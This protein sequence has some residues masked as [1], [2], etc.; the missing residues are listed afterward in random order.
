MIRFPF[1]VV[2]IQYITTIMLL[3]AFAGRTVI[4]KSLCL[5]L[6]VL[7][8]VPT[9]RAEPFSLRDGDRVVLIGSTLIEREQRYGYWETRLTSRWPE[10]NIIFRNLG[11]SG[12]T[13]WGESRAG[14]DTPAQGYKR[15]LDH[16]LA[17][18]PTV[19]IIGYGTNESFAG[20]AGLPRFQKQLEKL[21][22]DLAPSKARIVLLAP[23]LAEASRW[24]AGKVD[25]RNHDLRLYTDAI[26]QIAER[27]RATFVPEFCQRYGVADPLTDDGMQLTAF[28]YWSTSYHL[29]NELRVAWS[30]ETV[31]LDGQ[32]P[33]R[34]QQ[35]F[36]PGP[37]APPGTRK[38]YSQ[39]DCTV[40]ARNLKPGKYTLKIDGKAVRTADAET[41]MK[42][43]DFGIL[44]PAGPSLEQAEK[45]R[46][47]IVEKNRLYFYRWRPENETY[48]FGFRKHEQGQNARE[49]PQ[50]DPLIAA[51]EKEIA[52]LRVPV[53]HTYELKAEKK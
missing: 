18:K 28:G 47:T 50:F 6:F 35:K 39:N 3:H 33:V 41:W 27:R 23:P 40:R 24:P 31:E 25:D 53:P 49:I 46:R 14:F 5:P 20:A 45:L 21:L 34:V 52:K 17:L 43:G 29:L 36:L 7:F 48:L 37:P 15:L 2:R 19:L 4:V 51:K 16:T 11:W 9:L 1:F 42:P 44:V 22:D 32:A 26:K 10:C 30:L 12:D 8:F 38:G 13:V